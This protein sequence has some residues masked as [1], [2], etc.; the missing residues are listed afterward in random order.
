ML[1][2]QINTAYN[3]VNPVPLTRAA[4]RKAISGITVTLSGSVGNSDLSA[5]AVTPAKVTPGA[6]WHDHAAS[7][8]SGTSTYS[9]T[10][11]P[12]LGALGSGVAVSFKADTTCGAGANVSVSSLAAKAILRQDGSALQP[13]DIRAGQIV[14]LRY[15]AAAASGSGAWLLVSAPSRPLSNVLTLG[16]TVSG[17]LCTAFTVTPVVQPATLA[18]AAGQIYTFKTHAT[19][20][21]SATLALGTLAAKGIVSHGGVAVKEARW[22]ADE[23]IVV[24]YD[25]TLDKWVVLSRPGDNYYAGEDAGSTDAYALTLPGFPQTPVKGM[26]VSFKPHTVNTGACT[27]AINGGSAINIVGAYGVTPV[28]GQ[29]VADRWVQVVYDGT[30]WQIIGVDASTAVWDSGEFALLTSA[31]SICG[32][33]HGLGGVPKRVTA[34]LVCK[35]SGGIFNYAQDDELDVLHTIDRSGTGFFAP[36]FLIRRTATQIIVQQLVTAAQ[37]Q[38]PNATTAATYEYIG[39]SSPGVKTDWALKVYYGL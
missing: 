38:V 17:G 33:L 21:A 34:V 23:Y 15:D 28:S 24:A 35:K 20:A 26:T 11:S 22:I 30:S 31:G 27:L 13:G 6:Y 29:L 36:A 16:G 37:I 9:V 2:I 32:I 18:E 14:E 10:L 1:T 25:A 39:D 8:D 4:L 12:V 3:F 5:G 7:Y 19:N